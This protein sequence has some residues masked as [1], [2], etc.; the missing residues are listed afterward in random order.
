[1][2][3]L[4]HYAGRA[5]HGRR[6]LEN[7]EVAGSFWCE[8]ENSLHPYWPGTGLCIRV[9]P[10]GWAGRAVRRTGGALVEPGWLQL[11]SFQLGA[12][13]FAID[14]MRCV[15]IHRSDAITPVP[16]APEFVVGILPL[17]GHLI[18]CINL[19]RRLGLPSP[20]VGRGA[21]VL[22][23]EMSP[24]AGKRTGRLVALLVQEVDLRTRVDPREVVE[25][26]ELVGGVDRRFL[27]GV[28]QDERGL[29]LILDVD[30]VLSSTELAR[31]SRVEEEAMRAASDA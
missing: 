11:V 21:R 1:M 31:L 25:P 15:E 7:G 30:F 13:R 14:L 20:P 8:R 3:V 12:Q 9:Q 23:L 19:A 16:A 27:S 6:P 2:Q 5:S 26:P 17:R 10:Q 24:E 29:T 18:V 4:Y 22:V 28:T